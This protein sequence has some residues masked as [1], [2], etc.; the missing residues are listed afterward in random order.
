MQKINR[1][2]DYNNINTMMKLLYG[3][4]ASLPKTLGGGQHVHI[5]IIM[6]PQLY[7]TLVNTPYDSPP[8]P[9]I[10]PTHA[11]GTSAEIHQTNFLF[12]KEEGIIFDNHQT[13]ED[14]LKSVTIDAVDKLYIGKLC[15]K[16]SG[17]LGI[18]ARNLLDHL[19][20]CY[21]K[22]NPRT[23]RNEKTYERAHRLHTTD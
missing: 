19:L 2:P 9:S 16:Y 6:T 3:N 11:I 10:I 20:D 1:E 14:A 4:A 13:M 22:K 15:N 5:G 7:T 17:Y 21:E 12:H 23:S 18:T 8:D